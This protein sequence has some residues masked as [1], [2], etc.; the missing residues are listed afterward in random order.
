[1]KTVMIGLFSV[2]LLFGACQRSARTSAS[3]EDI[4]KAEREN[5]QA[6]VQARL[7][8]F[9]HRFDGLEARMKGLPEADR[10]RLKTDIAELRDRKDTL[11]HKFKDLKGVS[12]ESWRDL[13]SSM[14]H[15][16]D[17]LELAYNVVAA[18]NY[19]GGQFPPGQQTR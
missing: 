16:L 17:Q 15:G 2:C 3:P 6:L 8:E 1:M 18:N 12:V 11:Q 7:N 4:S 9:D 13:K 14:D 5:Y 19:G 10:Q